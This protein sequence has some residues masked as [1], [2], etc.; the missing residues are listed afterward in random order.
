VFETLKE[1]LAAKDK[2]ENLLIKYYKNT[3]W[4]IIRP[5]GLISEKMTGKAILT[6]DSTAIGSI[7]REVRHF[8]GFPVEGRKQGRDAS[9]YT[10]RY[11]I[12]ETFIEH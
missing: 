1:V 2:A 9:N 4:T 8:L 6:E 12:P 5:G 3:E 7:N 11:L 10:I